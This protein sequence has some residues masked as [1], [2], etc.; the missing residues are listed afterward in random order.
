L[1]NA[2]ALHVARSGEDA[3][4]RELWLVRLGR[5][6]YADALELQRSVARDRIAGTI[7][8]DVLLVVE[9]DP[10]ITLGRSSKAINLVAARDVLAQRGI[11]LFDVE[12]GGDATFHGPGQLVGYPIVDLK[13]HRLDLHWFLRQVEEALIRTLASYSVPAERRTG[14]TGVWTRGRKIASIGLH[15]RDWVTWHG[16]ALNVTTDLS[17]FDLIVPCGIDG[18]TMTSIEREQTES[19]TFQRLETV[20]DVASRAGHCFA[21]VLGL[22]AVDNVDPDSLSS[23]RRELMTAVEKNSVAG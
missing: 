3:T 9:H 18:V 21:E 17:G 22:T 2:V 19:G 8:Q 15:A 16:F 6:G 20:D 13:R 23:Q 1:K 7:E 12:R 11:E 5:M 10:V 4:A 14:Y